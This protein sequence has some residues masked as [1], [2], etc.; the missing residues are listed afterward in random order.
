MYI[1]ND[2]IQQTLNRTERLIKSAIRSLELY[3]AAL[4][5]FVSRLDGGNIKSQKERDKRGGGR[6]SKMRCH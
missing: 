2:K 6:K 3:S 5:G 1:T 4:T